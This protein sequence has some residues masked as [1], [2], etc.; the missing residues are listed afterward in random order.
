MRD[1]RERVTRYADIAQPAGKAQAGDEAGECRRGSPSL[2]PRASAIS[3]WRAA[4]A[5]AFQRITEGNKVQEV[6]P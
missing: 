3:T 4:L 6:S 2:A 1:G 5:P